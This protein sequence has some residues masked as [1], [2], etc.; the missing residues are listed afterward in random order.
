MLHNV[1]INRLCVG[2]QDYL[3]LSSLYESAKR[4]ASHSNGDTIRSNEPEDENKESKHVEN[5]MDKFRNH[6]DDKNDADTEIRVQDDA[7]ETTMAKE[8]EPVMVVGRMEVYDSY[9]DED[10]E[11]GEEVE[12][13][14]EVDEQQEDQENQDAAVTFEHASSTLDERAEQVSFLKQGGGGANA[15]LYTIEQEEEE[16]EEVKP[17]FHSQSPPPPLSMSPKDNEDDNSDDEEIEELERHDNMINTNAFSEPVI[18]QDIMEH[19]DQEEQGRESDLAYEELLQEIN[20]KDSTLRSEPDIKPTASVSSPLQD[21][22]YQRRSFGYDKDN[23]NYHDITRRRLSSI[24]VNNSIRTNNNQNGRPFYYGHQRYQDT[25]NGGRQSEFTHYDS[26]ASSD[27]SGQYSPST[28]SAQILHDRM[29]RDNMS[30]QPL[31][32]RQRRRVSKQ[33]NSDASLS[34]NP[35]SSLSS[36]PSTSSSYGDTYNSQRNKYASRDYHSKRTQ[37]SVNNKNEEEDI[38]Y[39]DFG[40]KEQNMSATLFFFFYSPCLFF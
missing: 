31:E 37:P 22:H 35:T 10:E 2:P 30:E 21:R 29:L 15:T 32:P 24:D 4:H 5:L 26:T 38:D 40:K 13:E 12:Y 39:I 9:D 8:G 27:M 36:Y 25:L 19:E 33:Y 14:S 16:E 18:A 3:K 34:S 20:S 11:E 1:F 6:P 17:I 23:M 28:P 7:K